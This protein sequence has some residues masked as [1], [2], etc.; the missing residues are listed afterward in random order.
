MNTILAIRELERLVKDILDE[1]RLGLE[2]SD[3]EY[4]DEMRH[5]FEEKTKNIQR[6][7]NRVI[8][9]CPK[10]HCDA[11]QE[12]FL[13]NM[14]EVQKRLN[15]LDKATEET[16][17]GIKDAITRRVAIQK[18]FC[19]RV[20]SFIETTSSQIESISKG[21]LTISE[22]I[23]TY[24]QVIKKNKEELTQIYNNLVNKRW[25]DG[26]DTS[27]GDF[28]HYFGGEGL[29]PRHQ[30][31]WNKSLS[32]L[33]AFIDLMVDDNNSI[34]KAAEI[35]I[36]CSDKDSDYHSFTRDTLKASRFRALNSI[37]GTFFTYQET[38][39]KEIFEVEPN[40]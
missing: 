9:Y 34:A 2:L 40:S 24:F 36:I 6:N 37:D 1:S 12:R 22:S 8:D 39:K 17:E 4:E 31:K 38:I 10:E 13:K 15:D 18:D 30:I 26:D 33:A 7:L 20:I 11:T 28:L 32:M 21:V 14:K 35:F 16:S 25:I 3:E 23:D 5:V 27:L 19:R 29:K